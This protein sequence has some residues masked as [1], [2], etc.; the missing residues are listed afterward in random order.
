MFQ[1]F[2]VQVFECLNIVNDSKHLNTNLCVCQLIASGTLMHYSSHNNT[3]PVILMIP[4]FWKVCM[5][6][7]LDCGDP[8]SYGFLLMVIWLEHAEPSTTRELPEDYV[9]R[10]KRVHESGGYGSRGYV[11][12]LNLTYPH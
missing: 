2:L 9:E 5:N 12:F 3:L 6:S 4:S 8:A 1:S 11:I 10:V 7:L